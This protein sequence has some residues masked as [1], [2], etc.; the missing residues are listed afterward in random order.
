M[1]PRLAS[2]SKKLKRLSLGDHERAITTEQ[3]NENVSARGEEVSNDGRNS[4]SSER[5]TPQDNVAKQN[6]TAAVRPATSE[7]STKRTAP[8]YHA[9]ATIS[10]Q[11]GSPDIS[12]PRKPLPEQATEY[13]SDPLDDDQ[14]QAS[15]PLRHKD[16]QHSLNEAVVDNEPSSGDTRNP[17]CST[18]SA[19]AEQTTPR[20]HEAIQ[21]QPPFSGSH[22]TDTIEHT[23]IA[24]A[25][26]HETIQPVIH[27][28]RAEKTTRDIHTTDV[29]HRILPIVDIEYLP[30][31]H[32]VYSSNGQLIEVPESAVEEHLG[33]R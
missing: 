32:F 1:S 16:G 10:A 24:P 22:T 21:Y 29:H 14:T 27:Q 9:E 18:A 2:I 11:A 30:A 28:V 26:T 17:V 23:H 7:E 19:H 4:T 15:H 33:L 8:K 6:M 3:R 25:V 31:R 5:H 12:I 13:N 20:S